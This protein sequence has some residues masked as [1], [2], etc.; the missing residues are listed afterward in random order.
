MSTLRAVPV[1]VDH[2]AA[3]LKLLEKSLRESE[4]V[5]GDFLQQLG[6]AIGR[7]DLEVFAVHINGEIAGAALLACR[8]SISAGGTFASIEELYVNSNFRCRG[9]GRALLEAVAERCRERSISYVEVQVEDDGAAEFYK[10]L[11][12]EVEDGVRVL[13]R[14]YAF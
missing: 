12:Y 3:P 6:G 7:G 9:V 14:S 4:P 5:P 8:L 2:L 10:K 13:S 11:G 1:P